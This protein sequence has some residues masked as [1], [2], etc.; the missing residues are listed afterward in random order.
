MHL[1]TDRLILFETNIP[2][3]EASIRGDEALAELLDIV[4]PENW[5]TTGLFPYIQVLE[6]M[7]ADRREEGWW[8]YLPVL[9]EE[10]KL[11]GSCGYKGFPDEQGIVEIGYEIIPSLRKQ[12]FAT[13]L[14]KE[15]I[16]HAFSFKEVKKVIA[17]TEPITNPSTRVL[18]KCGM[19]KT[20]KIEN[21][22]TIW[23][24]KWECLRI[25]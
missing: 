5:Q 2:V 16:N 11:I 4:V 13:E 10:K 6:K 1:T 17:H 12:G 9:K 8:M 23:A 21:Q 18:E 19:A 15:L 3:L 7:K 22:G 24:W 25:A 14:A 20:K